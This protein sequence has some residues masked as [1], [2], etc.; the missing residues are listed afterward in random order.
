M[1]RRAPIKK[2][3]YYVPLAFALIIFGVVIFVVNSSNNSGVCNLLN[4]EEKEKCILGNLPE[5]VKSDYIFDK[6][7]AKSAVG[8]P[9]V[10]ASEDLAGEPSTTVDFIN[11]TEI[12][13]LKVTNEESELIIFVKPKTIVT[14]INER[15]RE[16]SIK[17][18]SGNW[19]STVLPNETFSQ[20]FEKVGDY[21]FFVN[22]ER[23][24][25]VKVKD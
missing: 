24:G 8:N 25:L 19:G 13:E 3:K 10:L 15:N 4:G 7:L 17:G 12:K 23:V 1:F 11:E 5:N 2:Y 9:L 16:I 14:F 6:E 18:E 22:G 21:Y 20:L